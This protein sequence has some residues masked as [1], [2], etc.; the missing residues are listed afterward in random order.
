MAPSEF[1]ILSSLHEPDD[2]ITQTCQL[3]L[4]FVSLLMLFTQLAGGEFPHSL[5]M[6]LIPQAPVQIMVLTF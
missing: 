5:L 6:L 2:T 4:T 1:F 3:I